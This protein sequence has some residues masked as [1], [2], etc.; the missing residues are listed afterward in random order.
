MTN[1]LIKEIENMIDL[2]VEFLM[3]NATVGKDDKHQEKLN[4]RTSELFEEIRISEARLRN[5]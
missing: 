1:E 2:R 3:I 5:L 4:K